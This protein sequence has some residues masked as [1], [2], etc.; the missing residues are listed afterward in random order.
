VTEILKSAGVDWLEDST[1]VIT[2]ARHATELS[3]PRRAVLYVL[4]DDQLQRRTLLNLHSARLRLP[5]VDGAFSVVLVHRLLRSEVDIVAVL[6]EALRILVPGG[7]LV[8]ASELDDF[9]SFPGPLGAHMILMQ[10]AL[11]ST[12]VKHPQYLDLGATVVAVASRLSRTGDP[13]HVSD[14]NTI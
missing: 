14:G 9:N 10:R 13:Q 2:N 11:R 6:E 12:G 5:I 7:R 8:V 3:L 1:L 4:S